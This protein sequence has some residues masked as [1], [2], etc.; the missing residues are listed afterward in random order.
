V[1]HWIKITYER[2]TYVIDLDRVTAFCY[3]PSH[4]LSFT[5]LDGTTTIVVN[6]QTDAEA[7]Q[8]LLD[9]VE[10]RSGFPLP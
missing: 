9:Y 2:N 10:K 8:I 3:M 5:L 6:Q 4:R 7:Y 1:A